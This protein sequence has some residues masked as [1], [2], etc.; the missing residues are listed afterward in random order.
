MTAGPGTDNTPF[1]VLGAARSGTTMLRLMLNAHSRLAIPFES[2][3][4]RRIVAELP[5][6]RPLD[7]R[8]AGRMAELVVTDHNFPSWHLHPDEVRAALTSRAP[9]TLA[10]LVDALFR[11]EVAPTGKPRWGDKTPWYY[12]CRREVMALFPGS[13]VV[14]IVRDGRDVVR[15]L[16]TL[17]WHGPTNKDRAV[18]WRLRVELAQEAARELG[19][20]RNLI[21]RYEDLVLDTRAT[22]QTVC[23]FL[24]E[25]FEPA[26]L[27]FF[28]TTAGQLSLID[29]DIHR[30]LERPPRADDV[31]RW[32]REMPDAQIA[33]VQAV[34]GESL[35]AM[36][37]PLF[38]FITS[39]QVEGQDSMTTSFI[40]IYEIY[41]ST[42]DGYERLFPREE[43]LHDDAH[44]ARLYEVFARFEAFHAQ[45]APERRERI[46]FA[47]VVGGL[48]GLN[49]IP[50]FRPAAI[51]FFDVNP[52]AVTYF[53]L[54]R[55]A[56]IASESAADF[57]RRLGEEDYQATT[58]QERL[59]RRCIAARQNGTL[60]ENEGRSARTFLSSWRYAL[61][62]FDLTR[63]LLAEVPIQTKVE[64]MQSPSFA[65][66]IARTPN[67]WLYASNVFEFVT[68]DL[69][70]G[71]PGNTALFAT[72][73]DQTDMLDL[74][75][76]GSRPV[77]VHCGLPMRVM[78]GLP[79]SILPAAPPTPRS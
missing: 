55:R 1:F 58:D 68:L 42:D 52:H 32:R 64:A 67:L 11:M 53:W 57:L 6:D 41:Y 18:Y 73:F 77:T 31:E 19:P 74:G 3:F 33:E 28:E 75:G 69:R 36:G 23:D 43:P 61:D 60:A 71:F 78:S 20:E 59:I 54:I 9:A 15:S 39:R 56:W 4:L 48:Y 22:L 12:L 7:A 21:I 50:I 38:D 29:G 5:A 62:H 30:K 16:E 34:A 47:S 27:R 51:T 37:Y 25:R 79:G 46:H 13:K 72:Y 63:R 14:H 44:V 40:H 45:V 70:F 17:G 10:T 35:R 24:G 65:A 8:E 66:F 26:M 76:N 49:L 2:Q